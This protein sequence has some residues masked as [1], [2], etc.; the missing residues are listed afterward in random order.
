MNDIK[1]KSRGGDGE[2]IEA[3]KSIKLTIREAVN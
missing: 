3:G 2:G 1:I